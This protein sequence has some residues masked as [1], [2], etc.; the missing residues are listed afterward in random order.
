MRLYMEKHGCMYA[1]FCRFYQ[2]DSHECRDEEEAVSF[3]GT[4][5]VFEDFELGEEALSNKLLVP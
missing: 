4:F 5:K 1:G 3:C 2:K